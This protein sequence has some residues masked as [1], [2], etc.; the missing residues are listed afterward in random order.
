[1]RVMSP[2]VRG[3]NV[4]K[5]KFHTEIAPKEETQMLAIIF[6]KGV[7]RLRKRG[8]ERVEFRECNPE[9]QALDLKEEILGDE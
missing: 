9:C 6:G 3:G 8:A 2:R 4:S 1:M 5:E 7:I